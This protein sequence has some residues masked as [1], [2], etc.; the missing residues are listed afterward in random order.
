MQKKGDRYGTHRV[1]RPNNVLPQPALQ[2]DNDF[3]KIYDN[4]IL[5]DV[6]TLNIDAASF[7]D[8][9][10]QA[11]NDPYRI[12]KIM[13]DIVAD[14]GKLMNPRTGSG[15][16]FIGRVLQIG[17]RLK[18]KIALDEGDR[19]ASLVSLSLTP[20]KIDKILKVDLEKD[21]ADI[22]G[23]A[24]LFESGIFVKLPGDIPEPLAMAALDVAGAPAQVA[25]LVKPG[26][27]VAV[28]GARGKSGLLCSYMAKA[29]AGPNG[30]VIAVIHSEKGMEDAID[31]PFIDDV[32]VGSADNALDLLEK[33]ERVTHNRLC[34]VVIS[35]VSKPNCEMGAIMITK[36][37]GR[38][39]FFSMVTSFTK[40]AL[41]AEGI[42]KDIEMFIGNGYCKGHADLTLDIIRESRYLRDLYY[43]RYT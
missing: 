36:D 20:L 29:K 12:A 34:D 40:A 19:I 23:Q 25:I 30:R 18:G 7:A 32:I 15:G 31:A 41:G 21:H 2:L 17:D 3:S 1:I 26:N 13:M 4:E 8:L 27:T 35:C 28:L 42:G 24:V 22:I 43:K 14:S 6:N 39:Y 10:T 16:M 37:R 9:K 38:V 33:I 11:G 5:C